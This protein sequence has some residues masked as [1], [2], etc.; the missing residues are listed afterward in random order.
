MEPRWSL[1]HPGGLHCAPY[2]TQGFSLAPGV[3]YGPRGGPVAPRGTYSTQGGEGSLGRGPYSTQRPYGTQV[4]PRAPQGSPWCLEGS[5]LQPMSPGPTHHGDGFLSRWVP[6]PRFFSAGGVS[7]WIGWAEPPGPHPSG[8]HPQTHLAGVGAPRSAAGAEHVLGDA[9]GVELGALLVGHGVDHAALENV[10][11][12][13][14]GEWDTVGG[15]GRRLSPEVGSHP[16]PPRV[17]WAVTN[18]PWKMPSR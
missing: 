11:E 8:R 4:V 3:R 15:W 1:E 16:L 6:P 7:A 9:F 5:L 2:S 10:G 13:P 17:T 14:W 18:P 12:V